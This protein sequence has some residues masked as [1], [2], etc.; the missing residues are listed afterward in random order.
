[1]FD[2]LLGLTS[3]HMG[4]FSDSV[5]DQF[6]ESIISDVFEPLLQEISSLQQMGELLQSR[7]AEIDQLTEE[8]KSIGSRVHG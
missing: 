6:G 5:R 8:L 3:Q 7:V 4:K 2:D 1:M